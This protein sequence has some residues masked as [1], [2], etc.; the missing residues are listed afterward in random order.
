ML[1][2]VIYGIMPLESQK[3]HLVWLFDPLI[4]DPLM[5]DP[6]MFDPLMFDSL[7]FVAIVIYSSILLWEGIADLVYV[8]DYGICQ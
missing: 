2:V 6:L 7:I 8:I 1:F 5:F 4:F 3:A